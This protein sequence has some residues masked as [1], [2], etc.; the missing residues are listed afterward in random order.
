MDGKFE[1]NRGGARSFAS[2][3]PA[4]MVGMLPFGQKPAK[5][6]PLQTEAHQGPALHRDVD[7][8]PLMK[9]ATAILPRST[10][11]SSRT[12]RDRRRG[13]GLATR[14]RLKSSR[15]KAL[16]FPPGLRVAYWLDASEGD[17]G[18]LDV[19]FNPEESDLA[20]GAQSPGEEEFNETHQSR[21]RRFRSHS[22]RRDSNRVFEETP[23][24]SGRT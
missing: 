14:S 22:A 13:V 24:H 3:A 12:S 2:A 23:R 7:A 19:S 18:V 20:C 16:D 17:P 15:A 6:L 11:R 8:V 1:L 10:R 4:S 21:T 9:C 5:V